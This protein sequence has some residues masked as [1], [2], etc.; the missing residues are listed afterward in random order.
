[1]MNNS[2]L[3]KTT[4]QHGENATTP[5]KTKKILN[6]ETLR[7]LNPL[8]TTHPI[9]TL[10][11][12]SC[13]ILLH[14]DKEHDKE[15][16]QYEDNRQ[17]KCKVQL[18]GTVE[19]PDSQ[20]LE[21]TQTGEKDEDKRWGEK[22]EDQPP[23]ISTIPEEASSPKTPR[24]LPQNFTRITLTQM[25]KTEKCQR[26]DGLIQTKTQTSILPHLN[27]FTCLREIQDPPPTPRWTTHVLNYQIAY[28]R[29]QK[30]R[31]ERRKSDDGRDKHRRNSP[32]I[33]IAQ[34]VNQIQRNA[35]LS[36]LSNVPSLRLQPQRISLPSNARHLP[37]M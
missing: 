6:G 25:F 9:G 28:L 35:S 18:T 12:H 20:Q 24:E 32:L 31:K 30:R 4:L 10:T 11:C 27:P 2:R 37:L 8:V 17:A 36:E 7:Q 5:P 23:L 15:Q 14:E 29:K 19:D 21:T 33:H 34:D 13:R 22:D 26:K 3:P 1:M 16:Q